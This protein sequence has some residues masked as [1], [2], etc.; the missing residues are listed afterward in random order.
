VLLPVG[1]WAPPDRLDALTPMPAAIDRDGGDPDRHAILLL[2]DDRDV[3]KIVSDPTFRRPVGAWSV[4][5]LRTSK[6][7]H[8]ALRE[9]AERFVFRDATDAQ[10]QQLVTSLADAIDPWVRRGMLV[11][12]G[13]ATPRLVG[14][15]DR[16]GGQWGLSAILDCHLRPW[17]RVLQVRVAVRPGRSLEFFESAA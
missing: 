15:V 5:A 17:S 16:F 10:A 2:D 11:G 14:E 13:D 4:E 3:A 12:P 9:T 6:A 8:R 1:R 7:I